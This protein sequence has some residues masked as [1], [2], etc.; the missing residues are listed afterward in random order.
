M[1]T[2]SGKMFFSELESDI[3]KRT[4]ELKENSTEAVLELSFDGD[5]PQ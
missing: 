5:V 2:T 3:T 1:T 4:G